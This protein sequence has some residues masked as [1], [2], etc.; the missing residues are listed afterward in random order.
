MEGQMD[1]QAMARVQKEY[2]GLMTSTEKILQIKYKTQCKWKFKDGT[3]LEKT[4]EVKSSSSYSGHNVFEE[5]LESSIC[6]NNVWLLGIFRVQ[7]EGI[8]FINTT[9]LT[10]NQL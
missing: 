4:K 10:E 8:A 2:T 1:R 7:N 6:R 9:P 3:D 5:G